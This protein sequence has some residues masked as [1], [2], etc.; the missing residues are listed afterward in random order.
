[1]PEWTNAWTR[2]QHHHLQ[3]LHRDGAPLP[4][5][6]HRWPD[7]PRSI[8]RLLLK[9]LWQRAVPWRVGERRALCLETA[10][11]VLLL[12]SHTVTTDTCRGGLKAACDLAAMTRGWSIAEW[13]VLAQRAKSYELAR[14]VHFLLLLSEALLGSLVPQEVMSLLAAETGGVPG[15]RLAPFLEAATLASLGGVD[16]P[17]HLAANPS[18]RARL[19]LLA[20]G[21]F[22]PREDMAHLYHLPAQSLLDWPAYVWRPA[23]LAWRYALRFGRS[24]TGRTGFQHE[25]WLKRWLAGGPQ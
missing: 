18:L 17:V 11:A 15:Q 25:V 22:P 13:Q 2:V 6:L 7:A 5:E 8:G 9:E 4:I 20:D 10:D 21:L 24:S 14:P 3:A 1:V 19:R 23:Q 12:A 16:G